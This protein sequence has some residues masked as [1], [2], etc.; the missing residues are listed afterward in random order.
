MWIDVVIPYAPDGDLAEV[1]NRALRQGKSEW[2]LFLDHDIFLATNPR[3]YEMCV[4]VIQ[5]LKDPNAAA[6][7][8]MEGGRV[9]HNESQVIDHHILR[10]RRLYK[11]FGTELERRDKHVIG[12]F[13]LL[14]REVAKE[15]GFR[16]QNNGINNI[17]IDFGT[18]LLNEGYT[19]YRMRGLYVY[20]RRGTK[21]LKKQF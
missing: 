15:I 12:Y 19:I 2:V 16:K 17:D 13:M 3:W 5:E 14:R 10:A 9:Q 21:H 8:C 7:G 18:R 1:Y 20:H 11:R 4:K 6:I